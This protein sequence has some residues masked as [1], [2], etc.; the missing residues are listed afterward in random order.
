MCATPA[1]TKAQN[2]ASITGIVTDTSGAIVPD[3]SINLV[4]TKTNATYIGKTAGDGS[5]R[6]VDVPPGPDY[7]LTVKKDGFVA[8]T[9]SNLYLP[10]GVATTQDVKLEL[11][12]IQQTVIVTAEGS[13][14]LNTTDTTIGNNIDAHAISS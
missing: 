4:N 9:I 14:T 2:V 1:I 10:V 7:T 12:S 8:F 5:Y 6:I 13:V 3:A 11:G